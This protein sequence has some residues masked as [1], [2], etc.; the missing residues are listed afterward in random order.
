MI[1]AGMKIHVMLFIFAAPLLAGCATPEPAGNITLR[2]ALENT[3]VAAYAANKKSEQ[4]S[5]INNKPDG[6]GVELCELSANMKISTTETRDGELLLTAA[7][8]FT[9]SP[10]TASA[11]YKGGST[12]AQ[13]NTVSV[14]Y[15]NVSCPK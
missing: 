6:L 8:A 9:F 14:V 5:K 10:V 2:E 7:P 13:E 3:V 4:L 15:R 11:N 12:N 1:G